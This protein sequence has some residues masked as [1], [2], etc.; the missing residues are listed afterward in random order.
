[1]FNSL[2]YDLP[3]LKIRFKTV[4]YIYVTKYI[5]EYFKTYVSVNYQYVM[6]LYILRAIINCILFNYYTPYSYAIIVL[7]LLHFAAVKL[8]KDNNENNDNKVVAYVVG[9]SVAGTLLFL[10]AVFILIVVRKRRYTCVSIN[11]F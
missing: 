10:V 7:R 3:D 11:T 8:S 2:T 9:G 6:Y 1:V 4:I 5:P